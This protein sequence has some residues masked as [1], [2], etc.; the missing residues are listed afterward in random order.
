MLTLYYSSEFSGYHTALDTYDWME[1]HGDPMFHRHVASKF[2]VFLY[3]F[4]LQDMFRM[5]VDML[6]SQALFGF[7]KSLSVE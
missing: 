1:K 2:S 7:V 6:V 5:L 3:T 4:L